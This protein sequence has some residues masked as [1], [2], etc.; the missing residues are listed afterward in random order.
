[1]GALLALVPTKDWLYAGL[2]V[3]LLA[4]SAHE[5]RAIEA[6][7]AQQEQA[8]VLAASVKT[9]AAAKA[10]NDKLTA[11]YSAAVVT[12]GENYAKAMQSAD[13]AHGADIQ[14]LQQ[15]AAADH[16]GGASVGG[17]PASG[18]AAYAGSSGAS[19][20]GTVPAQRAVD[21]ADA[22]RADDAALTQCY[23]E[24]D[25]LTGK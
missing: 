22:L 12:V 13:A 14:R 11:E 23:A 3:I 21:L 8:A 17:A 15:R 18:T 9:Q 4:F 7:G 1:M 16:S 24:R 20:L 19:A 25:S 5:Y 6:K 10:V 2:F